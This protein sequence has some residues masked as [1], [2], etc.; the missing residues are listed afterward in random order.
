MLLADIDKF[1]RWLF[2]FAVR[3]V[4]PDVCGVTV[5][6]PNRR[7]FDGFAMRLWSNVIS[8]KLLHWFASYVNERLPVISGR[9]RARESYDVDEI[10]AMFRMLVGHFNS[11]TTQFKTYLR[12][13][14]RLGCFK[15]CDKTVHVNEK[16][17]NQFLNMLQWSAVDVHSMFEIAS[18]G[19]RSVYQMSSEIGTAQLALDESMLPWSQ[20]THKWVVCIPRKPQPIGMRTY[21]AAMELPLS[22]QVVVHTVFPDMW[23]SGCWRRQVC[24]TCSG[25]YAEYSQSSLSGLTRSARATHCKVARK[26]SHATTCH[27]YGR[28]VVFQP[29]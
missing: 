11:C 14:E 5:E 21:L 2:R 26:S 1:Q 28:L 27:H 25:E 22:Q 17:F 12:S 10:A 9:G 20:A 29:R 16:R 13:T 3:R 15:R 18:E 7:E 4:P 6:M 23:D 8:S 24:S 19:L